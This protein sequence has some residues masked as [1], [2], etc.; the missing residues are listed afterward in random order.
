MS[1]KEYA[2]ALT[3]AQTEIET[4]KHDLALEKRKTRSGRNAVVWEITK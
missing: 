4:L 1:T 2:L 3:K